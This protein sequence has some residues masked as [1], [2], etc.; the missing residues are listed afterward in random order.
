MLLYSMV[1]LIQIGS[2]VSVKS[3]VT[4]DFNDNIIGKLRLYKNRACFIKTITIIHEF[5]NVILKGI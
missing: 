4:L 2:K 5:M 1:K 3:G